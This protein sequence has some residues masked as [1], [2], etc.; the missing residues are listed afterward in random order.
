MSSARLSAIPPVSVVSRKAQRLA[1]EAAARGER[2]ISLDAFRGI[3][4]AGMILVN[5]PGRWRPVYAPLQHAEWNGCTAA[6]LIFPFFLFIVGVAITYSIVP[7]L[8][9]ENRLR[10]LAKVLRR[11]LIIFGLGIL[12]NALPF[13]DWSI[14]RIPGV[15]Q[16]IALCYCGAALVVMATDIRG[17]VATLVALLLGYWAAMVLIPVPVSWAGH[18]HAGSM[19][20]PGTNL[21]A[22]V[23]STLLSGHL[24]YR[25]WDPEGLFSTLP[26]IGTTLSGV[27][28][29]YWL[30]S[31]RSAIERVS[32][33]LVAGNLAVLAGL[34]MDLWF[35]INKNLWTTSYVAF[36]TGVA[37]NTLGVCYWFID[38]RGYQRW[39]KPLVIYGTNPLLAYVL[40]TLMA[41][42]MLLW[43][44]TQADGTKVVLRK[45]VF[46]SFFLT[47]ASPIAASFLYAL[48]YVL[49][50]LVLMA[51]L[52]R[53][54]IF[55]KI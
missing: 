28:A 53:R 30:R 18:R 9:R 46:Q 19:L 47:L 17:Q 23:D 25:R 13:F 21:A 37:L 2:L 32:G 34:A 50:W 29:G 7:R 48:S 43:R 12:I 16:R 24:L 8:E 44:V 35:P 4:I 1:R 40:S 38:V 31:P 54:R 33:L 15:L 45:Y 3:A 39:A 5:N 41:K 36:T 52:Y 10:L 42:G 6:D 11:T 26:A 49:F 22:Y 20:Q 55:V 14:L 51:V 27:L